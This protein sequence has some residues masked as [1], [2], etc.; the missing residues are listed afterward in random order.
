[1]VKTGPCTG[2]PANPHVINVAVSRAQTQLFIIADAQGLLQIPIWR[3]LKAFWLEA[4]NPRPDPEWGK[5]NVK[6]ATIIQTALSHPYRYWNG[7]ESSEPMD[8]T[9]I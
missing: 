9:E 2:F 6:A 4:D 7:S 1:M 8:S 5:K 3:N